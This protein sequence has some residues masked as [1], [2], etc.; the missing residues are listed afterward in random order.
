M[1][2]FGPG[3]RLRGLVLLGSPRAAPP[4]SSR[5]MA[6][7]LDDVYRIAHLA[8]IEIDAARGGRRAR[9]ARCDLRRDRRARGRRHRPA[10]SRWRT[11]RTSRCRCARTSSPRPISASEYQTLAPA[12][13]GRA[14]PRPAGGRMTLVD[15]R[16][17][18]RARRSALAAARSVLERRA[19]ARARS[20]ASSA[21]SRQLNAF[22][23]RRPRTARSRRRRAADAAIARGR[24]AVRSPAFRSRT[25]TCL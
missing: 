3:D 6:L 17:D 22:I 15:R 1:T 11:R 23:T 10:S 18:R 2:V 25:R 8:R 20:L 7:T 5:T 19:D 4:R 16:D 9:E 14:L 12:V 21:R 13:R 24:R